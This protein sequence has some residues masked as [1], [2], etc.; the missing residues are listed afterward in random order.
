MRK[1]HPDDRDGARRGSCAPAAPPAQW[2]GGAALPVRNAGGLVAEAHA[3]G[4]VS[5]LAAAPLWVGLIAGGAVASLGWPGVKG[6]VG[7][8][9]GWIASGP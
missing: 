6:L 5:W 3:L 4:P 7:E 1:W 8:P 2:H 9:G